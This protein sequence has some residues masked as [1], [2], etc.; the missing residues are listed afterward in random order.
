MANATKPQ[1]GRSVGHEWAVF[2][3]TSGHFCWPPAGRSDWPLTHQ[4][5]MFKHLLVGKIRMVSVNAE[6][7]L[8]FEAL[9]AHGGAALIDVESGAYF[10]IAD[11]TIFGKFSLQ[12][13]RFHE[14]PE[15]ENLNVGTL[16]PARVLAGGQP[17]DGAEVGLGH[18]GYLTRKSGPPF[19]VPTI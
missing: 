2:M 13:C 16:R 18:A 6:K 4:E 14:I 5:A 8:Y 3:A 11:S 15:I 17:W 7:G 1:V 12:D 10:F 19:T 9:W